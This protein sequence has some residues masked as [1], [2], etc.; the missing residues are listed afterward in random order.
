MEEV[1]EDKAEEEQQVE[2]AKTRVVDPVCAG[3]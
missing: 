2:E 1:V 3:S